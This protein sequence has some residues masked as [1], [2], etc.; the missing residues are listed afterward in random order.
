VQRIEHLEPAHHSRFFGRQRFTLNVTRAEMISCGYSPS[1]RL[2]EAAASGVP[3]ISDWWAGLDA[4][5]EPGREILV[6]RDEDEVLRYLRDIREPVRREMAR[7]ARARVFDQHTA[8]HRAIAL[9][10]YVEEARQR[11]RRCHSPA[12]CRTAMAVETAGNQQ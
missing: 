2:F 4:F 5:F 12:R 10:S 7:A 3:I 6:A 1:V 11:A 8:M 9:E